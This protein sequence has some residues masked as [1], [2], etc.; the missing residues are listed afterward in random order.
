MLARVR[1]MNFTAVGNL[2][3]LYLWVIGNE[4]C[5]HIRKF[6]GELRKFGMYFGSVRQKF[7]EIDY[8]ADKTKYSTRP[9]CQLSIGMYVMVS[10]FSILPDLL[11]YQCLRFS[12]DS[13]HVY[14]IN[15]KVNF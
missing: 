4:I 14:F 10:E 12:A 8:K 15:V 2:G 11:D 7:Y 9:A 1:F 5:R 13:M 6:A 3:L